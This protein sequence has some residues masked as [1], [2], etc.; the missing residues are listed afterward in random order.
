MN[1][2]AIIVSHLWKVFRLPHEKRNTLF[3]LLTGTLKDRTYEEFVALKN[4]NFTVKKGE[5]VGII[6][7]NGSGK[8]TL[9]KIITNILRADRGSVEIN[10]KITPF[11]EL[12]VGFQPDLTVKEN[13]YLYGTVMGLRDGKIDLD[14]ILNFSGL[15]QFR[16]AKLKNLSSGMQVRLAFA[17]AVQTDPDI[18]LLDEVLAVGD[19]EFQQKCLDIFQRYIKNKKTIVFVS[20]DLETIRR[21]CSKALLLSR[22]EQIAFGDTNDIVDR[23]IYNNIKK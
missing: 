18:L 11:L 20:H 16:A 13:V 12:G 17:T 19:I 10:G 2:D 22:G 6:G 23:Y 15:Q 14:E 9:L 4:I 5:A 1:T 3:E 8:S 21:F 7:A